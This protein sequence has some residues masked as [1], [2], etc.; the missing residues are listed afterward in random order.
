M[1]IASEWFGKDVYSRIDYLPRL[2]A[3]ITWFMFKNYKFY[4]S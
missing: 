4:H 1:V 3:L 2:K